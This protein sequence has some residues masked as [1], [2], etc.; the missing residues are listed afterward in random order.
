VVASRVP[1]LWGAVAVDAAAAAARP[2]T[3]VS[4]ADAPV[5]ARQGTVTEEQEQHA[6]PAAAA[7]IEYFSPASGL[8]AQ[9]AELLKTYGS[10]RGSR[11][12]WPLDEGM[13]AQLKEAEKFRKKIRTAAS[14]YHL[15]LFL[16][17]IATVLLLL[18][19]LLATASGARGA[20]AGLLAMVFAGLICGAVSVLYFF[21]QRYTLRCQR[22]A[23]LT[24]MIVFLLGVALNLASMVLA[25]SSSPQGAMAAVPA[26]LGMILPAAFAWVSFQAFTA[27]PKFLSQPVWAVE[28][29]VHSGL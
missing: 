11:E 27:I 1:A 5:G 4:T 19:G 10:L 29:L 22:W 3:P 24:M 20:A 8:R 6:V 16:G 25:A 18:V 26:L 9:T 7:P 2:A 28:A 23:P 13:L 14:L 21:C 15:L 17:I 12:Q